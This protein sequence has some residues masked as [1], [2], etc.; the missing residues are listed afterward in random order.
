[1]QFYTILQ[2]NHIQ[3]NTVD[4]HSRQNMFG[5]TRQTKHVQTNISDT[6]RHNR[7]LFH[8][9]IEQ[10]T[11]RLISLLKIGSKTPCKKCAFCNLYF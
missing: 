1:M 11:I 5:Q 7:N 9:Y 4:K 8:K 6:F 10:V 2:T 3:T